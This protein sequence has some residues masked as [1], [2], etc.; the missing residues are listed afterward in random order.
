MCF[1]T[2]A[3]NTCL[4]LSCATYASGQWT[5]PSL[6]P[7][8]TLNTGPAFNMGRPGGVVVDPTTTD[9]DMEPPRTAFERMER[10]TA[11]YAPP[12]KSNATFAPGVVS[13]TELRHPISR[14][15]L[16]LMQQAQKYA[17]K[18]DH[19]EAIEVLKKALSDSSAAAYAHSLLGVEYLKTRDPQT[20]ITHLKEAILLQ[21]TKAVNYSNLG[22]ALCLTGDR[23]AGERALREAI[24][25]DGTLLKAHFLLGLLLLDHLTTEA[26]DQ[27]LMVSEDITLAHLALA[28]FHARRGESTWARQELEAYL[29]LSHFTESAN[30][31]DARLARLAQVTRPTSVFGLPPAHD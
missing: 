10:E 9:V 2:A 21:P 12:V 20:A 3:F 5:D 28:V 19:Q 4:A 8:S 18:G 16:S 27:L 31:V 17:E 26:R 22:Y 25:L 7:A 23:G 30:Q 24:S 14:T 29:Q 13:V 15:G 6:T 11:A 1:R